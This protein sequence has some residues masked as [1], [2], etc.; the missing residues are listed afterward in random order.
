M[1]K[2]VVEILIFSL[3]GL[4]S[5]SLQD[6]PPE[7]FYD[8]FLSSKGLFVLNE[9]NFMAGNGSVSFYS[10]DSMKIYNDIFSSANSRPIG[11]VPNHMGIID[12]RAFIV[13]NNSGKIEVTS[14][15]TMK[16]IAVIPGL[17]SPR[18]ILFIDNN[19][20]YVSSLYST[21]IIVINPEDYT[22]KR[23]IDIRKTSESMILYK[24]KAYISCWSGGDELVI[25]DT[26]S[27]TVI[28]SVKVGHEPESM[29]IDRNGKLWVLCSGSYTGEFYP[30]LVV[31]NTVTDSVEKKFQFGSKLMYPCCL[32]INGTGDTIYF[33]E[34][35][36][37]RMAVTSDQLPAEPF[38][39]ASG[40]NFYK[41]GVEPENGRLYATNAIDYQQKGFLL[42][43]NRDGTVADSVKVGIIPGYICF[44][45]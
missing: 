19:K 5:C 3:I 1:N 12:N 23:Y 33:I 16:S 34:R 40:R 45:Q 30:E 4:T 8:N 20:A 37:W 7:P 24:G 25:V 17:T 44:K 32:R 41:I 21:K 39:W 10:T 13:V 28:D 11:D 38:I 43:F 29:A 18:Q 15:Q 42:I 27:D 9:G 6:D 35:S 26:S 36:I 2:R 22:I 14:C 31:I